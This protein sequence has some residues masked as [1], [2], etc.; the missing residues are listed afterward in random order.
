MTIDD[1]VRA[2]TALGFTERQ[3]G[4]LVHV[5]LFGGVCLPRQCARFNGR[6]Y[7]HVVTTFF[8]KLVARGHA[9]PC[10][11]LHNRGRLY[12][13]HDRRLYEA[14]GEPRH[15]HRKPVPARQVLDRLMVLDA[16]IAHPKLRWLITDQ[17]KLAFIRTIAPAFPPQR[18][19][20]ATT[21]T[22]ARRRV[23]WFPDTVLMGVNESRDPTFVYVV[24]SPTEEDWRRMVARYGDLLGALPRWTVRA[25]FPPEYE[26]SM[27][28]FHILFRE[29]L[30][31]PLSPR[32]IDDLRWHFEHL[33]APRVRLS[34]QDQDR[35][36]RGQVSMMI[37]PRFRVLY[38]RWLV[39]GDAAFEV[40]SSLQ[41]V[42]RLASFTGQ[43]N[44]VKLPVSY[45]HLHPLVNRGHISDGARQRVEEGVEQG[46]TQGEVPPA[47]PQP[48]VEKFDHHDPAGCARAWQR[49]VDAH[50]PHLAQ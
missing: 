47:R 32:T 3:A 12:H 49:L 38:D 28:R 6:A 36:H 2:V 19:P 25:C 13:I 15:P 18:L 34:E 46:A 17:E 10:R 8:A 39:D 23:R 31:E 30:A 41:I 24:T 27:V 33:N 11:C 26:P 43:V 48:P 14:I 5:M 21:G 4:F 45:R 1:R 40:A 22:G 9:T 16:A 20:H 44:C 35:F 37:T 42:D 7:G 29:E 50:N